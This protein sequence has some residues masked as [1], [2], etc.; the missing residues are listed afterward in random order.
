MI[1]VTVR[2]DSKDVEHL[3][4]SLPKNMETH[5]G[6]A[7]YAYALLARDA[8]RETLREGDS[9]PMTTA[10]FNAS[11]SIK[12]KKL[13]KFRSVVMMP[14]KLIQ[15]DS[16]RPHYVA[17]GKGRRIDRWA[18]KYFGTAT[19]SGRSRVYKGLRGGVKG[20][21]YV[22]PMPFVNKALRRVRRRLTPELKKGVRKAFRASRRRG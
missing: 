9:R 6:N 10:R 17:L 7:T 2:V 1:G 12:A 18:K 15:L 14:Q 21:M 5:V 20:F 4:R 13:S 19:V 16:S 3:M 22:T 8:M 11:S